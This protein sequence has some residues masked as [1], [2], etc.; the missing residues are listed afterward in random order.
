M[1]AEVAVT[2]GISQDAVSVYFRRDQVPDKKV[3]ML[4]SESLK[5]DSQEEG[6]KVGLTERGRGYPLEK[7]GSGETHEER[8][9]G[10]MLYVA[11]RVLAT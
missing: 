9:S 5:P 7:G 11:G 3:S 10:M 2:Q 6:G 4:Q 1:G 8:K